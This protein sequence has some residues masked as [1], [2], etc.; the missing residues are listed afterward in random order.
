MPFS[1]AALVSGPGPS[2]WHA[3]SSGPQLLEYMSILSSLCTKAADSVAS[4]D[5]MSSSKI[6]M[7]DTREYG[8]KSRCFLH[9]RSIIQIQKHGKRFTVLPAPFDSILSISAGNKTS[10]VQ[11]LVCKFTFYLR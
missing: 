11:K 5:L 7:P 10:R 3:E 9:A 4:V 6:R 2:I 8:T 1:K